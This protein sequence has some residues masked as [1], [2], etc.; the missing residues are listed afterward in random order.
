MD[1]W[2]EHDKSFLAYTLLLSLW[3]DVVEISLL[4]NSTITG[5]G[6]AH[7]GTSEPR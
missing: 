6:S 7:S 4:T 5:Q 2:V 1:N 3:L